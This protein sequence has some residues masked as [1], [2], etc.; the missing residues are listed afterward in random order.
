MNTIS[1]KSE[2]VDLSPSCTKE[3]LSLCRP[4]KETC[5]S[6]KPCHM[7]GGQIGLSS[8]VE[9]I[10]EY[11]RATR[12]HIVSGMAVRLSSKGSL[13]RIGCFCL[14]PLFNIVNLQCNIL[15]VTASSTLFTHWMAGW[16]FVSLKK[17]AL[18]LFYCSRRIEIVNRYLHFYEQEAISILRNLLYSQVYRLEQKQYYN[19]PHHNLYNESLPYYYLFN[20]NNH[21]VLD[22]RG[23]TYWSPETKLWLSN[24]SLLY[25]YILLIKQIYY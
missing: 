9:T 22:Q 18:C 20:Y 14:F 21:H 15:D 2:K 12:L 1:S 19:I 5:L 24:E 4:L 17:A 25:Y 8:M 23:D 13:L 7:V 10:C 16:K 11:R 3:F 6:S